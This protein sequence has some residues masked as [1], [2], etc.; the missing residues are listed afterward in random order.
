[1]SKWEVVRWSEVVAIINGKN[2]KKVE[3]INGKYPIYGSG[4]IMG[5]ANDYLC[6]ENSVVIGRKGN[7]NK[8]IFVKEKF[9]NVDTAFGL[10]AN[11]GRLIPEY[12]YY[13]C[14]NFNFENLNTTVTI[15]SLT[16]SNLLNIKIPL[17]PLETQKQ[18][19]KT[20]DTAADLLA[21]R[22]QQLTELDNLIKSLFYE[23]FGDPVT[24]R[25]AWKLVKLGDVG[26]LNSGGT[27]SRTNP[28][29]FMGDIDWYSAGELNQRYLEGSNE[30]ITQDALNNSAAKV[31]KK[32]SML[33]G[34]YDT[35]AFKLGI[36]TRD[37]S[38]NQACANIYI[39]TELI[40]IEWLYDCAQLMRP[41]FLKNRR[42]VRQK[43]LNLGMIKSLEIPLPPLSL[44]TNYASKITKIE[45]QK[46][47][48]Q[49]A[50]DE[51]QYLFDSL[52]SEYFD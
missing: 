42:G 3:D 28:Y 52:M 32:G 44:Q 40:N 46:A 10:K 19:A 21:M 13:F 34:M 51:T 26:E 24:N 29:Y 50:V 20:L 30:K 43:N 4:G 8:P 49:K 31:F 15:P 23:I 11:E 38:S 2:Q 36:L 41:H 45:E 5:Y 39:N 35:A 6:D 16:K 9:W 12:L 48:V 33:I 18:I 25:R 27:P 14:V 7:I 1:M 22:K 47:L 17:P 37:S